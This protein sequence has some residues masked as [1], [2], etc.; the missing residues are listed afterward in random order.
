[1]AEL[2]LG[3]GWNLRMQVPTVIHERPD[4]WHACYPEVEE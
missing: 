1:M 4:G 3:Q 2:V